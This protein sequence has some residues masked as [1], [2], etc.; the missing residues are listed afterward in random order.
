MNLHL[1]IPGLLWPSEHA[2]GYADTLALPALTMLLGR[3]QCTRT[4]PATPESML[5]ALFGVDERDPAD[6]ALRR[7][8]EEDGLRVTDPLLCADPTHLHFARDH[9]LLADATDL[10]ISMREAQTLVDSLNADFADIGRFE[11]VTPTHWYLSPQ[12]DSEVRFAALGEATSRPMANF[13]PEGPH[14]LA[15]HRTANEIQVYLHNHALNAAREARGLRAI[16][17]IWFWG[18]GVLPTSLSAPAKTLAMHSSQARGLARAAGIEPLD[19]GT[20]RDLPAT[21]AALIELDTL[22]TPS[23]YLDVERWQQALE[24]LERD[25]FLPIRDDLRARKLKSV[26]LSLPDERGS[27]RLT[28]TPARLLQ[29][30]RKVESLEAFTILQQL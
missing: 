2:R 25:W 9:L 6:A 24:D 3:S 19:V 16:N 22:L 30:W 4:T 5:R 13:M 27:R 14:A 21:D 29:F 28:L 10:D 20:Y 26:T 11:A 1:V 7:L 17:N 15:W 12:T 8:G 18:N 23:R